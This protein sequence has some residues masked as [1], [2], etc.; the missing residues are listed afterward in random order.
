MAHRLGLDLGTNSLGWTLLELDEAGTPVGI[1]A[2][3]A[4]IFSDGRDPKSGASLAED[5]RIARSMRRRRGFLS[6]RK[7]DRKSKDN[8]D[9]KISAGIKRL[10]KAMEEDN[11][12]TFGE[13][14]HNRRQKN[15]S[16]RTRLRPEAGDDASGDGYD[17]YPD[18]KLL[19]EEFDKIWTAQEPYYLSV[20]TETLK[21]RLHFVI[22]GQRP[23]KAPKVGR[24]T[25]LY[26]D[27][28]PK[29]HPLFQERRLYEEVSVLYQSG[30]DQ[31]VCPR[32]VFSAQNK[33]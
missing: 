25:F 15:L 23:L 2:T 4:R 17:F 10:S 27:R 9:G 24:C 30:Y 14:L 1:K 20:L 12:R 19:I 7:A 32:L 11:A 31:G 5:R 13:F 28:L 6:N 22:F 18:R 8:E 16:V 21:Y 26:E 33:D 3:G 29:A